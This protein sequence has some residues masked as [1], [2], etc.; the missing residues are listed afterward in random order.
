MLVSR[1]RPETRLEEPFAIPFACG[2]LVVNFR[3]ATVAAAAAFDGH[4]AACLGLRCT[5]ALLLFP[6]LTLTEVH[7]RKAAAAALLTIM[8]FAGC[9]QSEDGEETLP[10]DTASMAPAPAPAPMP[11]DSGM[12]M[13]SAAH[14]TMQMHTT[15]Q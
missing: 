9:A 3:D 14:D 8:M 7:M 15:T 2:I 12:M 6:P 4:S 10:A 13:D 11:M 5:A 1:T